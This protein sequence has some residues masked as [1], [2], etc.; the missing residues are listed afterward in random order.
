MN[1][2][3]E[4]GKYTVNRLMYV[5]PVASVFEVVDPNGKTL[6]LKALNRQHR[7]SVD[8]RNEFADEAKRLIGL[9]H[10]SLIDGLDFDFAEEDVPYFVMERADE[11]LHEAISRAPFSSEM[12]IGALGAVADAIDFLHRK[13]LVHRDVKPHNIFM[14]GGHGPTR[15]KLGDLG[16]VRN[17]RYSLTVAGTA[18]YAAVEIIEEREVSE[19][20]RSRAD[21]YS[22]AVIA[23]QLL[24]GQLPPFHFRDG[25]QWF[26]RFH[27]TV[28][29][30]LL[31]GM[32]NEPEQRFET[33]G[34]FVAELSSAVLS[35]TG[36]VHA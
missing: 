35:E 2:H 36:A 28:S 5:G 25:G 12:S 18:A 14:F 29:S 10:P 6:V 34:G 22:L 11:S 31:K 3:V 1:E 7:F 26:D 16:L 15:V 27:P 30:V 21:I 32:Q 13:S 33:A 23:T 19:A 9:D 4:F 20:F 24:A 8:L 17:F